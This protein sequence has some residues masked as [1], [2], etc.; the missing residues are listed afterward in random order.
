MADFS[1]E[2]YGTYVIGGKYA[3]YSG[4]GK[5]SVA[6][7]RKIMALERLGE[8]CGFLNSREVRKQML[9]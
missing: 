2:H 7:A 8:R 1:D 5:G 6:K 4:Q 3:G 9:Y